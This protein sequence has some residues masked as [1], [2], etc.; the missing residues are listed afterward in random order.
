MRGISARFD[1]LHHCRE[2]GCEYRGRS[3]LLI[4]YV[5]ANE[6]PC[7]LG[8]EERAIEEDFELQERS[9][10]AT[11]GRCV[12]ATRYVGDTARDRYLHT[13]VP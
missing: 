5:S 13:S 2:Q 1:L 8:S 4:T 7:R 10:V 12:Q 6:M 9:F 3:R 11:E